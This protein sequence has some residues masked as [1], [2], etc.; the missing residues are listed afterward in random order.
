MLYCLLVVISKIFQREVYDI[1]EW[2]D[3][4]RANGPT[5]GQGL[6]SAMMREKQG[7]IPQ[8]DFQQQVTQLIDRGDIE[9]TDKPNSK[10]ISTWTLQLSGAGLDLLTEEEEFLQRYS[11]RA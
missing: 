1:N 2:L 8:K 3:L 10:D 7:I 5:T 6:H 11:E 4:L 9:A